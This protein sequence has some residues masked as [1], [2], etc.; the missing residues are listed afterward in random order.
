MF[1]SL[2]L[3]TKAKKVLTLPGINPSEDFINSVNPKEF[4]EKLQDALISFA[5]AEGY[6]A[7]YL[8][9]D[10]NIYSNRPA[11]T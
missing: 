1:M 6:Q 8:P 5:E 4:F 10:K 7:I 2:Q 11:L 9:T 3:C